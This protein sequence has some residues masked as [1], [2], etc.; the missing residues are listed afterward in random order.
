MAQW[1]KM[2]RSLGLTES[3]SSIYL[4]SLEMG[5][6]PVQDIARKANVSRMTTY[7]AIESLTEHGLMS[8]VQKGKKTLYAAESPERLIS[9]VHT[10]I[11]AV[12]TTL[13][14][15][16]DALDELKLKQRGEKPIVKL[17][18]G[19]EA[20]NAI[21]DDIVASRPGQIDEFGNFDE[22]R[23]IYPRE[24]R[25]EFFKKMEKFRHTDRSIVLQTE[26]TDTTAH[27]DMS[28]VL[29]DTD[30]YKFFGDI[31]VYNDK[32]A[33]STFRGKQISVLIQSQD[34][35][36]TFRA[37]FDLSMKK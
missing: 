21:Q 11:R 32:V 33:L 15:V 27:K 17:F 19:D 14:E 9:F 37:F 29:L 18:E 20:L 35:A 13:H 30:K 25:A 6:V 7:T 36:D 22:I 4:L 34:L 16:Q 24:Q 26:Q 3:E 10:K 8:S 12:E 28:K 31:L 1:K 2:L 23:K 5:P